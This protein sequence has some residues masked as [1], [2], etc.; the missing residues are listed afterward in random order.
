MCDGD[1]VGLVLMVGGGGRGTDVERGPERQR[2]SCRVTLFI[3]PDGSVTFAD[4][5][6]GVLPLAH[7]LDPENDRVRLARS[8]RAG[9]EE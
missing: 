8:H 6:E 1:R 9:R 7:R 4:L 3:D 2:P 5:V